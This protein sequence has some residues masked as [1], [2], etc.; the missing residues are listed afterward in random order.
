M[1]LV[2]RPCPAGYAGVDLDAPVSAETAQAFYGAGKRFVLRYGT[3]LASGE[4][5][6]IC[7]AGL[8]L[9]ILSFGRQ[10]DYT[11]ATGSGDATAIL[12]H[13]RSIAVPVG[14]GLTLGLD[15]ET[16]KGATI[17]ELQTYEGA[18]ARTNVA[19]DCSSGVYVG[20][21]LGMT[22]AELYHLAATHYYKSGSR[23]LDTAGNAAEPSCGYQLTQVLPF[24]Q[25]C[26]GS[27]VDFDFSGEDFKGRY[28]WML[29]AVPTGTAFSIPSTLPPTP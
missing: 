17:P 2:A 20:A 13:L 3:S 15:L 4:P 8:G 26:G 6:T 23:I 19:A 11:G 22:S 21:G 27:I 29:F 18:F 5:E 12:D 9:G 14:G 16:P 25:P 10:S 24:G 7:E 28:W 1:T